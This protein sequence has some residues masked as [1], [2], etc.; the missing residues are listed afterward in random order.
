[1]GLALRRVSRAIG[2]STTRDLAGGRFR[3]G[4]PVGLRGGFT[5]IEVLV[6]SV[7]FLMIAIGI[8]PL[9]TRSIVS[10]A[11]G[12]DHTRVATFTR[13]RGEELM[14]LPFD[15]PELTLLT[16]TERVFDE[17]YSQSSAAWVDGTAPA[18]DPALWTRTTTIRQFNI[19]DLTT[20]LA[21]TAA[22]E[23]VHLKEITVTVQSTRAGPLGVGKQLTVRLFKSQ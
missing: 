15:S 6:A 5:V 19:D 2:V 22:A 20:P 3:S 8:L 10:N 13:A 16:G 21:D 18:G 7:L 11:E 4:D 9:F 14:Q 1:M 23:N 12:F 17:Y